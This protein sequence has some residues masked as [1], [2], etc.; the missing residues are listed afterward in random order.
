[1][2]KH[3]YHAMPYPCHARERGGGGGKGRQMLLILPWMVPALL[4]LALSDMV[5]W[6]LDMKTFK[7][8][9]FWGRP[10]FVFVL[11]PI[12]AG[13]AAWWLLAG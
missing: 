12:L 9:A 2:I 10:V 3:G 4:G 1:M 8:L 13:V 6:I 11:L 7:V 5:H